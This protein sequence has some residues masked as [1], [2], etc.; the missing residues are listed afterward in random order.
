MDPPPPRLPLRKRLRRHEHTHHLRFLTFSTYSRLPL[1]SN[2]KIR[3]LFAQHLRQTREK[4]G[5]HLYAWVVMPEHVHL[6]IWPRLPDD[7]VSVLLHSL[8]HPFSLEVLARWRQLKAPVLQ[9]LKTSQDKYRFWQ[10][11]GGHDL[12]VYS[13]AKIAE[14][15][16]YTHWNPVKRGLA[17]TPE[18]WAW[19]S[20]RWY[21]GERDAE[22]RID[23][24]PPKRPGSEP[25]T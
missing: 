9:R 16:E 4:H 15:I 6:L 7:P 18:E 24:L 23:P 2:P 20:A 13:Q 25:Q 12:N 19:S 17:Q 11:G 14:K 5:F 8:K 21:A 3:D 10:H 1:L 22:I